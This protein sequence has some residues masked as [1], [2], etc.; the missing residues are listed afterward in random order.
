MTEEIPIIGTLFENYIPP[1]WD[2]W[3]MKQVYLVAEKSKDPRTKI[4]AILTKDNRIISSGYNGFPIGINDHSYRYLDKET[5]YKFVVHAEHNAVLS[6][7]RFGISSM[8]S[9]LYTNG[10]PCDSCM[11]SIIQ[12]GV[13]KIVIHKHWPDM[14]SLK[15][16]ESIKVSKIMMEESHIRIEV[17]DKILNVYGYLEG[18]RINV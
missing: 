15:W 6:C 18:K 9:T 16:I 13:E 17:L 7:A 10:I 12:G 11:K 3:F 4:G 5:K 2:E 1:S 14:T 8:G